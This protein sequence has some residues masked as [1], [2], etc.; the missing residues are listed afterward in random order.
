MA[1]RGPLSRPQLAIRPV[2]GLCAAGMIRMPRSDASHSPAQDASD[3][4]G[5]AR[6]FTTA[7]QID[8]SI[9]VLQ[10]VRTYKLP[11]CLRTRDKFCVNIR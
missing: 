1:A 4:A 9:E 3:P 11:V 5:P 6:A 8:L 10:Y 2:P 7:R